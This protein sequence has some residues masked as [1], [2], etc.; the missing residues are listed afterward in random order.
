MDCDAGPE[1]DKAAFAAFVRELRQAFN[2]RGLLLSAAVSPSKAVIDAGYDVPSIS[3]DL[4]WIGVMTYDYH[5]HWDKK[6]G[7]VAPMYAHSKTPSSPYFNANYTLHRW[8]QLGADPTK[9]IM[10]LP[11]YGQSFTLNK[12]SVHGLNAP[13]NPQSATGTAGAFTRQKGFLAYYEV[14]SLPPQI[15]HLITFQ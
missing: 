6:T 7:H 15:N 2:P 14:R 8:L 10:G 11:L 4:D 1:S 13:T 3:R 9:L 5:G 12:P